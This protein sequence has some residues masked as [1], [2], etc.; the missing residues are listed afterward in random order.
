MFMPV[1]ATQIA[2][3]HVVAVDHFA[4]LQHFLVASL[5]HAAVHQE[6]LTSP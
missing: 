4:D 6:S 5:R 1:S 3:D 2:F